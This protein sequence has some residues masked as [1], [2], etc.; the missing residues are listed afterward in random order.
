MVNSENHNK[1]PTIV[2]HFH[3]DS[4]D[5]KNII[6]AHPRFLEKQKELQDTITKSNFQ[7]S[8]VSLM[9]DTIHHFNSNT[10]YVCK[11][12]FS[13][14]GIPAYSNSKVGDH[15]LEVIIASF[16]SAIQYLR[17]YKEKISNN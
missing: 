9:I 3:N 17:D 16:N 14:S 2:T 11:V 12:Q 5:L 1:K 4:Q 7:I 13:G 15:Y 10:R 8:E 6:P